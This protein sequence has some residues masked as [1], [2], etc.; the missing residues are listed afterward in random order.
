MQDSADIKTSKLLLR[1]NTQNIK[2]RNQTLI[3]ANVQAWLTLTDACITL[4][5]VIALQ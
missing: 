5:Y 3:R 2:P 1:E 4:Y